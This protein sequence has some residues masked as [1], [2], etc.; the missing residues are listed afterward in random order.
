MTY[1]IFF[2]VGLSASIIG[3]IC[4]VGGGVFIKPSLDSIGVLSVNSI[5]FLS[6]CTVISMTGYTVISSALSSKDGNSENL[7]DWK[8]TTWLAIGS[9]IGGIIGKNIYTRIL[10]LFVNKEAVGGYQAIALFISMIFVLVYTIN[11]S[12]IKSYKVTNP[13]LL[14]ILG[15][16][17]G[18]FS[19]FV[20]IGGGPLNLAIL[21]YFLSMSTKVAAQNSL[22]LILI[23]QI[24][25]LVITF[26]N[27]AVPQELYQGDVGFWTMLIGM[28]CCGVGGGILGKKINRQI[29]SKVVD[30]LFIL[31]IIC[32]S[33]L[34]IWNAYHKLGL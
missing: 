31:S 18:A 19:T 34:C 11:K 17:L 22:Y 12:K 4:G 14:M 2:I 10:D 13:I 21:Y 32:I 6:T 15:C 30:K 28:M 16:I 20:G 33:L 25:G 7:I 5:T 26:M 8:L 23:S 3:A 24:P 9:A 29:S 1:I 27:G